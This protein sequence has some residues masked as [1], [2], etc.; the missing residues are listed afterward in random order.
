MVSN[1]HQSPA[2]QK[3]AKEHKTMRCHCG[4][5]K[6]IQS[7]HILPASRFKSSRLWK[8]N[9]IY[10]CEVCNKKLGNRIKWSPQAIK[11]LTIILMIKIIKLILIAVFILIAGRFLWIDYHRG[12]LD[13]S[14]MY[15]IYGEIL[16]NYTE[17]SR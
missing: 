8:S 13:T 1:F 5:A 16:E 11:L 15:Q 3:L 10:Q 2:W 9:L 4:S 6:D 7:G 17:L 12:G 14:I